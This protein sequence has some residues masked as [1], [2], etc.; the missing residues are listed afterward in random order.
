MININIYTI[1]DLQINQCI[2]GNSQRII[3]TSFNND[4]EMIKDTKILQI[5]KELEEEKAKTP[6]GISEIL[7]TIMKK[8]N[9]GGIFLGDD[10]KKTVIINS[11]IFNF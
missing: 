3:N 5:A 11:Q 9:V 4:I 6:E 2:A 1:Y 10:G 7:A 8:H